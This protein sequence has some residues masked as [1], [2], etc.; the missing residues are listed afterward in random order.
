MFQGERRLVRCVR[1]DK[2]FQTIVVRTGKGFSGD[3]V[4]FNIFE[5]MQRPNILDKINFLFIKEN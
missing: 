4:M 3:F 5:M 2:E 1:S